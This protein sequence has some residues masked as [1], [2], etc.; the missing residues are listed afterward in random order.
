MINIINQK[1]LERGFPH[2][3]LSTSSSCVKK[4]TFLFI[5]IGGLR[6]SWLTVG[7]KLKCLSFNLWSLT[8]TNQTFFRLS[9]F[10]LIWNC[11]DSAQRT[12]ENPPFSMCTLTRCSIKLRSPGL[13][14][15]L[16]V[17]AAVAQRPVAPE[18]PGS[19]SD[20]GAV[21]RSGLP[22]LW[23]APKLSRAPGL[24]STA[25]WARRRS[26]RKQKTHAS[27]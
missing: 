20:P 14:G 9:F 11:A 13:T 2:P 16:P 12:L 24:I 22:K 5:L 23:I 8:Q 18:R 6:V 4:T 26:R 19:G 15:G 17:V 7:N 10:F 27:D 3:P 25:K 1:Q 21:A